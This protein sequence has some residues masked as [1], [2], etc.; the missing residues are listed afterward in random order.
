MN[1]SSTVVILEESWR[2]GNLHD[3]A[4]TILPALTVVAPYRI[5]AALCAFLSIRSSIGVNRSAAAISRSGTVDESCRHHRSIV[6]HRID[7]GFSSF[8]PDS[9]RFYQLAR[10]G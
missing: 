3:S 1:L 2:F 9:P 8:P 7:V 4:T 6:R 5:V 10:S